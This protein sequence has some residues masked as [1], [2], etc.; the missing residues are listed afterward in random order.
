MLACSALSSDDKDNHINVA[1]NY[2]MSIFLDDDKLPNSDFGTL[3]SVLRKI[4][5]RES[6]DAN[7]STV[8]MILF[9]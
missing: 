5:E 3:V 9:V 4:L 1:R 6:D 2:I 8:N 7:Q